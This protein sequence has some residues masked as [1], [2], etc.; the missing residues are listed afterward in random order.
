MDCDD[1]AT[2]VIH[3]LLSRGKSACGVQ[4]ERLGLEELVTMDTLPALG[5]QVGNPARQNLL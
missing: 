1:P 2:L 4:V 5:Q 3:A